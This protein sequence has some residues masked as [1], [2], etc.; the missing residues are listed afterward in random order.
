MATLDRLEAFGA[1]VL[2]NS[3]QAAVLAA[4]ISLAQFFSRRRLS[5][6]LLYGLW[7]L[8]LLKLVLPFTP[9]SR[10]SIFQYL[11]FDRWPFAAN[12]QAQVTAPP[13]VQSPFT[14][15]P[16]PGAATMGARL[17]TGSFPVAAVFISLWLGGVLLL[18]GRTLYASVELF[19]HA[20]R[21]RP[22]VDQRILHLLENCKEELG[23]RVPVS[24]V[25]TDRVQSPALLGY[26][27]PRLLLPEKMMRALGPSEMR[28]VFLHELAHL[29]RRD[30][31]VNWLI[32][33]LQI[34]HWFNPFLWLA[35]SRMRS[36]QEIACDAMVLNRTREHENRAYGL[37]LI[38]VLELTAKISPLPGAAGILEDRA[39]MQ[40]SLRTFVRRPW[41]DSVLGV[42][43]FLL[44]GGT[45]LTSASAS[46][47]PDRVLRQFQAIDDNQ[48]A[49]QLMK[50]FHDDA[51][52]REVF[53]TFRDWLKSERPQTYARVFGADLFVR[54]RT[55][56]EEINKLFFEW[57]ALKAQSPPISRGINMNDLPEVK[58]IALDRDIIAVCKEFFGSYHKVTEYVTEV[59]N[60]MKA[61][62]I[63]FKP[64]HAFGIYF[65]DYNTKKPEELRSF[66]GIIVDKEPE[67]KA[68]YFVYKMKKG[69]A[70]LYTKVAGNPEEMIPAGYMALF[71]HMGLQKIKAGASGG[72]QVVTME[73]GKVVFEI[74]LEI[75]E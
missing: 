46:R 53:S 71:N 37:T 66:Q 70:Y 4:L 11:Q 32:A 30:V 36:D 17:Q 29:K 56:G 45:A 49:V 55:S 62:Q 47:Q 39:Y 41:R 19:S 18:A 22:V 48:N 12:G 73:D 24:I 6:Q 59:E 20:R 23:V 58:R 7:L 38:K 35:F 26:L 44:L 14:V 16:A 3:W 25:M 68:P 57:V 50:L 64:Y 61:A 72:H 60:Y 15:E 2:Q 40:R 28:H 52:Y 1:W 43:L 51:I 63:P 69:S 21:K 75:E 8:L 9:E 33:F 34:L 74:Y 13:P 65:D 27:R 67:T 10:F 54:P 31:P 42:G 5:P